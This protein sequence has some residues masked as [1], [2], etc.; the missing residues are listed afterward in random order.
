MVGREYNRRIKL[1]FDQEGIEIPY[2]HMTVYPGKN[3]DGSTPSYALAIS[4]RTAED[5]V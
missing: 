4:E 3:K 1:R 5:V 2:P